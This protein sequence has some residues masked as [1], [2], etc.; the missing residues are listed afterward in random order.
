MLPG[1]NTPL[2]NF[3]GGNC[4]AIPEATLAEIVA[5]SCNTPFVGISEELGNEP[6]EDVTERFGFGQQLQILHQL[7][8]DQHVQRMQRA[9]DGAG[10]WRRQ[11][12]GIAGGQHDQPARAQLH[13]R[14]YGRV[15][16]NRAVDQVL[17]AGPLDRQTELPRSWP[18]A[19]TCSGSAACS[20]R[21]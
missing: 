12:A 11:R 4:A 1:T 7:V 6:F 8:G 2:R 16:G 14:R 21:L 9:A 15:A 20:S 19:T 17:A 5:Q 13:R 18:V 10:G 3:Y